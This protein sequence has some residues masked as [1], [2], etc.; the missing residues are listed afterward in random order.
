MQISLQSREVEIEFIDE[1]GVS[2]RKTVF[3]DRTV[4]GKMPAIPHYIKSN[5]GQHARMTFAVLTAAEG[6]L[7]FDIPLRKSRLLV[8][9]KIGGTE[10]LNDLEWSSSDESVAAVSN[11]V[12]TGVSSGSAVISAKNGE[13]SY[14][15]PYVF[16]ARLT[17]RN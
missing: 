14:H 15:L 11:G 6:E 2:S 5:N 10:N 12:V 1:N 9:P 16:S 4:Y 3:F 8:A 17:W 7:S 13:K